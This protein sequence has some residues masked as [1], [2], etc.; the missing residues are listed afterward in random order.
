VSESNG[1]RTVDL[2]AIRAARVE[3]LG[4]PPVVRFNGEDVELPLE[5]PA[6]YAF[7]WAEGLYRQAIRE[8][9]GMEA[10]TKFFGWA[11]LDDV[12]AFNREVEAA[13]GLGRG[14]APA[15]ADS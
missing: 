3:K 6:Q 12:W 2:D 9:V 13:Y 1:H 8:L 5:L 11:A 10:A 4:P 14:E 7:S 15:S